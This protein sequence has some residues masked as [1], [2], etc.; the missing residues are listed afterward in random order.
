MSHCR[1]VDSNTMLSTISNIFRAREFQYMVWFV[2]FATKS[3]PGARLGAVPD[4]PRSARPPDFSPLARH[5]I[6]AG[7]CQGVEELS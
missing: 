2:N 7:A 3:D 4:L 1:K 5:T 6:V